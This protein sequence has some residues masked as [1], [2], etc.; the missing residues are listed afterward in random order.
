M[1]AL[2]EE[3]GNRLQH[4]PVLD[5]L[6]VRVEAED[7]DT[8]GFLASPVQVTH[9]YKGQIAIDGDAFDIAEY[10]LGLFDVAHDGVEPIREKRVVL[11]IWP[12]H[13]TRIQTGLGL[14]ENLPV[15]HGWWRVVS[16]RMSFSCWLPRMLALPVL[17]VRIC[18]VFADRS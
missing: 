15:K 13:E 16:G 8:R 18:V 9:V 17:A 2:F 6:A 4:V 7:V 1:L 12:A 3:A 5:D 10:A 11:D 14:V